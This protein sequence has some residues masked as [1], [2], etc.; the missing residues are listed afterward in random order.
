MEKGGTLIATGPCG[1]LDGKGGR[2]E[3]FPLADVLGADSAGEER[4]YAY[5]AAGK[6][7][8][9]QVQIYLESSGHRLAR[10]LA[11]STVGLA[12]PF[13][14][15]RARGGAEEVMHYRLPLMVE[16]LAE[17]RWFNWGPPPPGG[18]VGGAAAVYN[19]FGK[20][21]A[22]YVGAGV[23]GGTSDSYFWMRRWMPAVM[24]E[25]VPRPL[26]EMRVPALSD[27]VQGSFFW[28]RTKRQVLVQILN[29]VELATRGEFIDVPYVEIRWD[30]ARLHVTGARVAWP[31]ERELAVT[32]GEGRGSLRVM[33][34]GRYT[35]LCLRVG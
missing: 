10:L 28:D 34:P 12:G 5:D 6:L 27:H 16:N 31:A 4:K 7:K 22:L 18:E 8:D 3:N 17:N 1:L 25:L 2:R 32:K 15:L 33:T 11:E 21:Q 30:P 9:S 20:G 19:R 35:A 23:F 24:R 14:R 29:A 26:V 13:V